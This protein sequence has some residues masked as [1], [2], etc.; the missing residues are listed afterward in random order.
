MSSV[1]TPLNDSVDCVTTFVVEL[2][3]NLYEIQFSCQCISYTIIALT[4][5]RGLRNRI[6]IVVNNA[7]TDMIVAP[8][9]KIDTEK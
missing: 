1:L 6:T 8:T 5:D 9:H 2:R 7:M 3:G 4:V